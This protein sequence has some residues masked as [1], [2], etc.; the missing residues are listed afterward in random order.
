[1]ADIR[2]SLSCESFRPPPPRAPRPTGETNVSDGHECKDMGTCNY[3]HLCK[4]YYDWAVKGKGDGYSL[5]FRH[6]D[7]TAAANKPDKRASHLK[8]MCLSVYDNVIC[9][10]GESCPKG[11]DFP[12]LC[13]AVKGRITEK[14]KRGIQDSKAHATDR[15]RR[16]YPEPYV[17]VREES[18]G[19]WR[20]YKANEHL[21]QDWD[22]YYRSVIC[23]D[24]HKRDRDLKDE[25]WGYQEPKW[26]RY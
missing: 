25:Y 9:F 21:C 15:K 3:N 17:S 22:D 19:N 11:H 13:R 23:T 4:P 18:R 20:D 7:P 2:V 16:M 24:R 10:K 5:G 12:E 26:R 1:M 6:R 8:P 14:S